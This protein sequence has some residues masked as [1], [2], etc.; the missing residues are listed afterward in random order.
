MLTL[1]SRYILHSTR[2]GLVAGVSKEFAASIFGVVEEDQDKNFFETSATRS[3]A[4]SE[5]TQINYQQ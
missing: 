4:H 2:L 1:L 5:K 3:S